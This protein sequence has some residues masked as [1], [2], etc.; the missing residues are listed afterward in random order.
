MKAESSGS[1]DGSAPPPRSYASH[2]PCLQAEAE[3][4][5]REGPEQIWSFLPS[6]TSAPDARIQFSPR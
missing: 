2:L 1:E 5:D 4:R 3:E 6:P